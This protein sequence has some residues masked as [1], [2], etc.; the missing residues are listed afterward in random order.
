VPDK[1]VG[2]VNYVGLM[3]LFGLMILVT[4]KDILFPIQF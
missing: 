1:L 4:I 2:A 3:L